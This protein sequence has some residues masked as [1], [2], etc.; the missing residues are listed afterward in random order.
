MHPRLLDQTRAFLVVVDLQEA[1]R[2]TLHEWER[3]IARA[4]VLIRGAH[5]LEL[6]VFYTEQYPKG[7][8]ETVPEVRE[9]LA[10]AQRFEKRTLSALGAPGLAHTLARLGRNQAIVAGIETQACINQT[11]HELLA[12]G[13]QVHLAED[14]LSSRRPFDHASAL[15]K[16]L[17]SGAIG[18][19]V[20][21]LL[22]ECLRSADHPAFKSVQALLK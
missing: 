3:T 11:V 8:G 10:G 17:A 19:S 5:A 4:R 22:F 7:L 18:G 15:A 6:P 1:F 16:L 14:A 12:A 13:Y 20:E 2:K 9:A 21:S